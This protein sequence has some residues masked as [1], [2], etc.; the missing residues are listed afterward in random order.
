MQLKKNPADSS[1]SAE[2]SQTEQT[3]LNSG[4][5]WKQTTPRITLSSGLPFSLHTPVVNEGSRGLQNLT[6]QFL[7]KFE[8]HDSILQHSLLLS[9]FPFYFLLRNS[10]GA[11]AKSATTAK[12]MCVP[13][14]RNIPTTSVLPARQLLPNFCWE[15]ILQ[16]AK[17][18]HQPGTSLRNRR[19]TATCSLRSST[20]CKN[21][22]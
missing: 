5:I 14:F 17:T 22:L 10:V 1:R 19:H 6:D 13:T 8:P 21:L 18:P 7:L 3:K 15:P 16:P 4:Q 9:S 12:R 20:F 2:P 11:Q